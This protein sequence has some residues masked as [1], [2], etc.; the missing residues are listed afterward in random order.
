MYM[1]SYSQNN[2]QRYNPVRTTV[3]KALRSGDTMG[4]VS[5]RKRISTTGRVSTIR[6]NT[7]T[8][9]VSSLKRTSSSSK[10]SSLKRN[11]SRI[12]SG[13]NPLSQ[14]RRI[15]NLGRS[16]REKQQ[17]DS[18]LNKLRYNIVSVIPAA[19]KV[20]SKEDLAVLDSLQKAEDA[21]VDNLLKNNNNKK[22]YE[23][24]GDNNKPI[25]NN[26][27][28]KEQQNVLW[29]TWAKNF[30]LT[31]LRTG[32]F[33]AKPVLNLGSQYY[34]ISQLASILNASFPILQGNGEILASI[35]VPVAMST[36]S[37]IAKKRS[38]KLS[39]D[40]LKTIAK[41]AGETVVSYSLGTMSGAGLSRVLPE[42]NTR[43]VKSVVKTSISMSTMFVSRKYF[44]MD[45]DERQLFSVVL[46]DLTKDYD[47]EFVQENPTAMSVALLASSFASVALGTGSLDDMVTFAGK[48]GKK[49]F[50]ETTANL[51]IKSARKLWK[52]LGLSEKP[53]TGRMSEMLSKLES[54]YTQWYRKRGIAAAVVATFATGLTSTYLKETLLDNF[55]GVEGSAEISAAKENMEKKFSEDF[56]NDRGFTSRYNFQKDVVAGS[57]K[58][59]GF[60]KTN[61]FKRDVIDSFK[62]IEVNPDQVLQDVQ[63]K[64]FPED[65]IGNNIDNSL[66]TTERNDLG[67]KLVSGERLAEAETEVLDEALLE[68]EIVLEDEDLIRDLRNAAGTGVDIDKNLGDINI[69]LEDDSEKKGNPSILD[70]LTGGLIFMGTRLLEATYAVGE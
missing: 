47:S 6:R 45:T 57:K 48:G 42:T 20:Q 19:D 51:G 24:E 64:S 21:L 62:K 52:S 69:E 54:K 1:S 67:S 61:N 4:T 11:T 15:K 65:Y 37:E 53:V 8:G 34:G 26:P 70:Y 7:S 32:S 22:A 18:L 13:I 60:T 41:T 59:Q 56:Q 39:K 12:D 33:I 68:A 31:A 25:N 40:N 29:S 50:L 10:V 30:A 2:V 23:S 55:I 5:S 14:K 58:N 28:N 46:D 16:V 36:A 49:I 66:K 63:A 44:D 17:I 3:R 27:V 9:R 38:L 43:I 35:I